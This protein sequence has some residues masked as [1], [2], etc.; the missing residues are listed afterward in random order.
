MDS[1]KAS[2]LITVTLRDYVG[3]WREGILYK[4]P[5]VR[6]II[7]SGKKVIL[8]INLACFMRV[9]EHVIEGTDPSLQSSKL[10]SALGVNSH[11]SSL[12]PNFWVNPILITESHTEG[13]FYSLIYPG[14]MGKHMHRRQADYLGKQPYGWGITRHSLKLC[15]GTSTSVTLERNADCFNITTLKIMLPALPMGTIWKENVVD[16]I[17]DS[18]SVI[19]G[20]M[21]YETLSG[22]S[23]NSVAKAYNLWPASINAYRVKDNG[24]RTRRSASSWMIVIPIMFHPTVSAKVPF[25]TVAT[26]YHAVQFLFTLASLKDLVEGIVPD[27]PHVEGC[28]EVDSIILDFQPRENLVAGTLPSK[29]TTAENFDPSSDIIGVR[30]E[31]DSHG[32][33]RSVVC[34][35]FCKTRLQKNVRIENFAG[36]S[37]GLILNLD[38]KD[39]PP[40]TEE[41][42]VY[43]FRSVKLMVAR[44]HSQ[45]CI[46]HF[47]VQD[48]AIWNWIKCGKTPPGEQTYLLP[49]S[50]SVFEEQPSALV[51]LSETKN[52]YL[53]FDLDSEW[54]DLDWELTC[55]NIGYNIWLH[56]DGFASTK[57]VREGIRKF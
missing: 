15:F 36:V 38:S 33:Q 14:D 37:F 3:Q 17:L 44:N 50:T 25:P 20:G 21:V 55:T 29:N 32:L 41:Q 47:D 54:S 9:L 43:P 30:P 56:K 16:A 23:N 39:L 24:Y 6:D 42:V 46:G 11:V 1:S 5:A 34:F 12:I 40:L 18:W 51:N 53:E 57:S 31:S 4:L 49:I 22:R 26:A 52:I 7:K 48:M 8:D 13:M 27:H 45:F 35:S 19:V 10:L 28:L 2:H